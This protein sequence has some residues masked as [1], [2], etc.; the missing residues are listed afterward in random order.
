ME[1]ELVVREVVVDVEVY[2]YPHHQ[3]RRVAHLLVMLNLV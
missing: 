2:P 3:I 1:V